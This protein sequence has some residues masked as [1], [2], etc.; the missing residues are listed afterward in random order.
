MKLNKKTL[1]ERIT[2]KGLFH[3]V[4]HSIVK[5]CMYTYI[6]I[7]CKYTYP[8][9]KDQKERVVSYS[10]IY[11]NMYICMYVYM[12]GH[13]NAFDTGERTYSYKWVSLTY[14]CFHT[15]MF[16]VHTYDI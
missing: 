13:A 14:I 15:N 8:W 3:V 9:P 16:I 10:L 1:A 11:I 4:S 2:K 7:N 12:P 6:Y 5:G